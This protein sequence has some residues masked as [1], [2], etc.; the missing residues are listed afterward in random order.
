MLDWFGGTNQE[1]EKEEENATKMRPTTPVLMEV[2]SARD[3]QHKK[4]L[5]DQEVD[6][7]CVIRINETIV[8]RTST[9]YNDD[10]PIWTV[11]T[12]SLCLVDIPT[13]NDNG[14]EQDK[15]D[16]SIV[17]EVCHGSHCLGIVTIPF[18]TVLQ[19][20][21]ERNEYPICKKEGAVVEVMEETSSKRVRTSLCC[22]TCVV[23]LHSCSFIALV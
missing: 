9:I 6:P 5:L 23:S 22:S 15:D 4:T 3:L 1:E 11:K 10:N 21:E 13:E 18:T 17:V 16:D 19:C 14:Q 12:K 7:Y 2:V 20:N 8:H